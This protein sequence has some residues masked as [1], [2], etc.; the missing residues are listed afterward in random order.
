[1]LRTIRTPLVAG[2][3]A[4]LCAGAAQAVELA[5]NGG[6]ETGTFSGWT[7]F[8]NGG[9]NTVSSVNPASGTF[10]GRLNVTALATGD[11]IKQ[12]NIGIGTVTAS[13]SVHIEFDARG[14][15]A[16]GGV[17]F[18]EFF[19]E[20]S[21][22]GTSSSVIL[23]GGPLSLNADPNVWTRFIFNAPTGPDVSGGVTLQLKAA[24]GGAAGSVADIF[25]DNASVSVAAVPIPATAW[26]LGTGCLGLLGRRRRKK[27][28]V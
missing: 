7:Q 22:G 12:A 13:Q 17:A 27:A 26:L 3:A 24:T 21:G 16:N 28:T 6:F 1:M 9:V 19:S 25:Y 14:T 18:A 8:P 23:S 11:V 10:S 15:T 20:L 5:V 2:V 4:L